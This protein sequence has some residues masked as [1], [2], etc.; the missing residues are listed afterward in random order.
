M[1]STE[2]QRDLEKAILEYLT[3]KNYSGAVS[4]LLKE[5]ELLKAVSPP[6]QS[7]NILERKWLTIV[8]LQSKI[9]ELEK[10]QSETEEILSRSVRNL[11]PISDLAHDSKEGPQIKNPVLKFTKIYKGHKEAVNGV[12]IHP[13][14]PVFASGSSDSTIRIFDYELQNQVAMLRSHTH[15]VNCLTWDKESLFSGSSDMT[16]KIWASSNKS[17]ANDFP[18]FMCVKTLIGHDHSISSIFNLP[19]MELLISCSRDKTIKVWEKSSGFGK[20]TLAGA[21]DDWIRSIDANE[22]HLLSSGN[23][24]KLIVFDLAKVIMPESRENNTVSAMVNV[25]EVHENYVE[26]VKVLKKGKFFDEEHVAFTASRDKNIGVWNYLKGTCL[27]IFKGHENWVKDL[28]LVEDH[29][30]LLSVGEDKA[31]RIWDLKKRKAVGIEKVAHEHFISSIQYHPQFRVVVTGSVDKTSKVWKLA[32]STS[33]D[34]I[35]S[36]VQ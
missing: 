14:E 29:G 24:R 35:Q 21:H 33:A 3:F 25:F 1:L 32:N 16:I 10:K 36:I 11:A 27:I 9:V 5:S 19:D 15:S 31:I 30:F 20:R 28:A 22:K 23:D 18:E 17:N 12:A 8:K 6:S 7:E 2:Q 4:S 26:C 13:S 34:I